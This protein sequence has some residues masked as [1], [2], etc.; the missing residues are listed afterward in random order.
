MLHGAK[1][2]SREQWS[3]IDSDLFCSI[4]PGTNI[5]LHEVIFVALQEKNYHGA[6]VNF[7]MRMQWSNVAQHAHEKIPSC[8]LAL[9]GL[10]LCIFPNKLFACVLLLHCSFCPRTLY[11]LLL[12]FL[13]LLP[14]SGTP[15]PFNFPPVMRYFLFIFVY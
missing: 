14:N 9:K 8:P 1:I 10:E 2:L 7:F 6:H 15:L 5:L 12:W 3:K 4:A 11:A 13:W